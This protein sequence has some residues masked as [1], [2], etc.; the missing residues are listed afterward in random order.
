MKDAHRSDCHFA[1][2]IG[3]LVC[4]IGQLE[5]N[6]NLMYFFIFFLIF[7][8]FLANIFKNAFLNKRQQQVRRLICHKYFLHIHYGGNEVIFIWIVHLL[9]K[10]TIHYHIPNN[11][12]LSLNS[13]NIT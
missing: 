7:K 5:K 2:K 8:I 10:H 3:M 11:D 13:F 6:W 9:K 12:L 4:T 1:T